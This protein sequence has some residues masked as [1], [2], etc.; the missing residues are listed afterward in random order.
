MVFHSKLAVH[1]PELVE[2]VNVLK[3][4]HSMRLKSYISPSSAIE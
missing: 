2:C 4:F 1:G 3:P